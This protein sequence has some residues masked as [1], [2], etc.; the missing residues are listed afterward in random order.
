[1]KIINWPVPK[2]DEDEYNKVC[3]EHMK[4]VLPGGIPGETNPTTASTHIYKYLVDSD[5]A[6]YQLDFNK[7]GSTWLQVAKE[8]Y[9][10]YVIEASQVFLFSFKQLQ[11]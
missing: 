8:V 9:V 1:M 11:N 6:T 3:A 5:L 2:Y 10:T 4:G 7:D